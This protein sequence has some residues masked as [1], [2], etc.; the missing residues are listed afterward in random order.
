MSIQHDAADVWTPGRILESAGI[1]LFGA[2]TWR[3]QLAEAL[4]VL[5]TSIKDWETGRRPIPREVWGR[6]LN[7]MRSRARELNLAAER[8]QEE[9]AR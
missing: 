8:V 1:A 2:K 6:V 3:A 7:L 4:G 9:G 5:R